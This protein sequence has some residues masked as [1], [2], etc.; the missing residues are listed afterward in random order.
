MHASVHHITASA[1]E[2]RA[3][4]LS[5]DE[6]GRLTDRT[7]EI[8]RASEGM[9]LMQA[10]DLG[11]FEA[12]PND[13]FDWVMAVGEAHPSAGWVAGVVGIH[14]WQIS[15]MD[16][17]VQDEIYG[18]DPEVWVASPY[19]PFGRLVPV[20]GGYRFTGRWPYS[21]GTDH[22]RWIILGGLLA[23]ESGAPVAPGRMCHV[24][25][26]RSGYEVVPDSW[27][28]LGLRGTGSKDVI[29]DG[30]FIPEH[31]VSWAEQMYDYTY[32]KERRPETPL[33]QM[34]FGLM[35]PAAIAAGTFG[36]ARNAL[37][38]FE[39]T[40]ASR[41]STA[42][43][44]AKT[45]P[46]Q[47]DALARARADVEASICHQQSIVARLHEQVEGGVDI[48]TEQRIAFRRDQVRATSRCVAAVDDLF[49]FAGS[50]S[51][52]SGHPVERVWRD[53]HVAA[54]HI[55]NITEAV[56]QG[57]GAQRFGAPLPPGF[58]Y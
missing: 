42:G 27:N 2:L 58:T 38:V 21:T 3:E 11:G 13:F 57:W 7:V 43:T 23:D 30:A 12:H 40:M 50:G 51:M 46:L 28:V 52:N 9:K 16:P 17:L 35:F 32:A 34:G 31:R 54:T 22:A 18:A 33:Y 26:P 6:L 55:C 49:R 19:A 24:V 4:A 10:K 36:I 47:L 14:P 29:V 25:L 53:L 20:E 48:D 45:S 37:A 41:I 1:E 44:V 15:I 5:S 8:L 39:E 56:Y